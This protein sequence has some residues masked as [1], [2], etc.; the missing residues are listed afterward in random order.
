MKKKFCKKVEAITDL[1][2][3]DRVLV[4]NPYGRHLIGYVESLS[5]MQDG[6]KCAYLDIRWRSLRAKCPEWFAD[7]TGLPA[8]DKFCLVFK[9]DLSHLYTTNMKMRKAFAHLKFKPK[10]EETFEIPF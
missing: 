3:G 7:D 1:K 6:S 9:H 10:E 8:G 4:A 5:D 2:P